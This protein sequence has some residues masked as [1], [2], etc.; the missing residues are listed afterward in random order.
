MMIIHFSIHFNSYSKQNPYD[1]PT[2]NPYE[3]K[4]SEYST[5]KI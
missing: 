4:V 3:Y 1:V 2:S 5:I